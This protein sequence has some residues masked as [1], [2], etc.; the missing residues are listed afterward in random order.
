M[1]L[2]WHFRLSGVFNMSCFHSVTVLLHTQPWLFLCL[3]SAEVTLLTF[4]VSFFIQCITILLSSV[5]KRVSLRCFL[6]KH[7]LCSVRNIGGLPFFK[8]L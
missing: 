4:S 3:C 8:Q 2:S 7:K 1:L 6:V 5:Y